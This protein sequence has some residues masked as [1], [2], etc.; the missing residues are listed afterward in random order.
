M[1]LRR[2]TCLALAAVLLAAGAAWGGALNNPC[3]PD[4]PKPG[5][6]WEWD[7]ED[8]VWVFCPDA[9]PGEYC[10]EVGDEC[11]IVESEE[12]C[13]EECG[14]KGN[15]TF[16]GGKG[17]AQGSGSGPS[18]TRAGSGGA[19]GM[20]DF[21]I[22]LGTLPGG[23]AF[24]AIARVRTE[25]PATNWAGAAGLQVLRHG[26]AEI[27][28]VRG[29][30]GVERIYAPEMDAGV[31][32]DAGGRDFE[33]RCWPK[34]HY[35]EGT[36]PVSWRVEAA[37]DGAWVR[38]TKFADG[39]TNS[40]TEYAV[41]ADGNGLVVTE[42]NGLRRERVRVEQTNGFLRADVHEVSGPD[43]VVVERRVEKYER[44]FFGDKLV[45]EWAGADGG[46]ILVRALEY[47][48]NRN[49][50]GS[51]G[52]VVARRDGDGGWTR[53]EYDLEGRVV[54][55]TT[56]WGDAEEGAAAEACRV[57]ETS[58]APEDARE[59]PVMGDKRWRRR[60]V[61]V[62]GVWQGTTWRAFFRE[63]GADWEIEEGAASGS[64]AYG[65]EGNRR[66]VRKVLPAEADARVRFQPLWERTPEG[67]EDAWEYAF[68][69][70]V[71]GSSGIGTFS[72]GAGTAF[73]RVAETRGTN[74]LEVGRSV[75]TV[76]VLDAQGREVQE[77]SWVYAGGGE[78]SLMDWT[79]TVRDGFGRVTERRFSD[80]N[81][82]AAGWAC[83][84]KDWERAAD[85]RE[86][87]Y[88]HDLLGRV[89]SKAQTDGPTEFTE[90]DAAGRV[91]ARRRTGGGLSLATS[92][93]WDLSGRLVASFDE[94]GLE[95]AFVH[96]TRT[97]T[98]TLPGGATRTTERLR[99]G[100]VRSVT[101]TA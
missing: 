78:W 7:E 70:Y 62:C 54:R 22:K 34:G 97:E 73:V 25:L 61:R 43:G 5:P 83:C 31:V 29:S 57:V 77:E 28:V 82:E 21:Q 96:G 74:W 93:R 14:G 24:A 84:G 53:W 64:S 27:E 35:G 15:C 42:G 26:R 76:R 38:F 20:V 69:S 90:Y 47:G 92:N 51:F 37:A 30:N 45:E 49:E 67:R 39:A 91:T 58:Y 23:E 68:G 9:L 100:R 17:T 13:C 99:D 16:G 79:A 98:V 10:C 18:G 95:T 66:T 71:L 55:E 75:R 4:E 8:C 40:V 59:W 85:G 2:R 60:T 3:T 88:T 48:T 80:G 81:A 89:T 50:K 52:R 33:L 41:A 56:G 1:R 87:S 72:E 36:P 11:K 6:C 44:F 32:A 94:A 63:D 101:G 46:G 19:Q 12:E 65:D 86:W